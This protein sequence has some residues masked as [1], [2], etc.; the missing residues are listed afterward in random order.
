VLVLIFS[1]K[2]PGAF[3][4]EAIAATSEAF[5]AAR[6]DHRDTRQPDLVLE[7][8]AEQIAAAATLGERDPLR[9][10]ETALPWLTRE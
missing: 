4:P 8:I 2:E 3:D 9:L 6:K 1:S 5:D 7:I 10:R